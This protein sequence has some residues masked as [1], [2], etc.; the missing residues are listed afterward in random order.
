MTDEYSEKANTGLA[1]LSIVISLFAATLTTV[2]VLPGLGSVQ[3]GSD[4]HEILNSAIAGVASAGALTTFMV[5]AGCVY[6]YCSGIK[7]FV[8]RSVYERCIFAVV[9]ILLSATVC[10]TGTWASLDGENAGYPWY[11]NGMYPFGRPAFTGFFIVRLLAVASLLLMVWALIVAMIERCGGSGAE[12]FQF[13]GKLRGSKVLAVADW[14]K[15]YVTPLRLNV[16]RVATYTALVTVCWL[17]ILYINGPVIVNIDTVLQLI[18]GRGSRIWDPMTMQWLDG[19]ALQDH[20]PVLDT[21]IYVAFDRFGLLMGH[22]IVGLQVLVLLQAMVTAFAVV[23]SL[24][25]VFSRVKV[26]GLV[27]MCCVV[28]VIVVPT[29]S[30]VSTIIVKDSTWAPLFLLWAITFA[31][32]I[33]RKQSEMPV[34]WKLVAL[35]IVL[36]VFAG[37]TKKTSIYISTGATFLVLMFMSGRLKTLVATLVPAGI[38]VVL[39]PGLLF[40]AFR[41][42]PGGP[43]EPLAMPIQQVTKVLIDHQDELSQ[44][45][46]QVISKVINVNKA[47]E[48]WNPVSADF[49]KHYGYKPSATKADRSAFEKLWVILA[50]RYPGSYVDSIS[51]VRNPFVLGETYYQTGPVKCGWEGSGTN[52]VEVLPGFESCTFSA[53]QNRL[54][55]PFVNVMNRI[56]PFSLLGAEVLYVVWVPLLAL[57]LVIVRK[58]WK[59][60]L[61]FSPVLMQLL[62]QFMVPSYQN[63]YTLGLLFTVFLTMSIPFLN[64][65]RAEKSISR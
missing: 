15:R 56:P 54:G 43:Q 23:L 21:L 62:V 7:A 45:D 55:R 59:S 11:S 48:N 16:R 12:L 64:P 5:W 60:L 8:L 42:A 57:A 28:F 47:K 51:Y 18:Q 53:Q 24:A 46:L 58:R 37:L 27:Q 10:F 25:W 17:P 4:L 63:R 33:Y 30:T 9:A 39:I 38:C 2:I 44:E 32:F 35:L 1:L 52:N 36:A 61:Y 13:S 49:A 22:E 41:I 29:F 65:E 19:Y 14:L 26:P 20:H 50:F 31:E 40:P 34:S 3:Q 6:L